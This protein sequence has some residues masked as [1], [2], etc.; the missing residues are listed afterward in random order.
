MAGEILH[1]T[2]GDHAVDALTSSGIKG[3]F[4]A[5]R[6]LLHEGP[7][8]A[9]VPD[10]VLSNFRARYISEQGWGDYNEVRKIFQERDQML[11]KHQ[12][13]ERIMLWF[14][15]D[16]Y[17]QL[18]L[19][20]VVSRASNLGALEKLELV[21]AGGYL[22][23]STPDSLQ[24]LYRGRKPLSRESV[25]TI[26]RVWKAYRASS[27]LELQALLDDGMPHLAYL[28]Q[29]IERLLEE[30]PSTVNGLSRTQRQALTLL[31]ESPTLTLAEL[32]DRA[33]AR[34]EF[35]Y[36]G[37]STFAKYMADLADAPQP[38][39]KFQSR[40]PSWPSIWNEA[41]A[42]TTTGIEV[43]RGAKDHVKLNGIDRWIGGTHLEGHDLK[44]RWDPS[45]KRITSL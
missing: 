16:L 6:D 8:P 22:S 32:F 1:I 18:Q 25:D 44:W 11:E 23:E 14:E 17:D 10:Q 43:L 21:S 31:D 7:V 40:N 4:L 42:I 13:F 28:K 24:D 2:N 35:K 38:L 5:W 34:E 19:L 26:T 12:R 30:Y 33:Q 36:L 37:D 20:D 27:P 45:A 3:E 29:A 9:G 41:V 15:P 39:I